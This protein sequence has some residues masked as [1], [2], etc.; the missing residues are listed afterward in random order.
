M[1]TSPSV[2]GKNVKPRIIENYNGERILLKEPDVYLDWNDS[3]ILKNILE[4]L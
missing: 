3:K 1:D 4:G 2:S